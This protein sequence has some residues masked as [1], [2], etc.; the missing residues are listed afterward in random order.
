M[1]KIHFTIFVLFLGLAFRG[2]ALVE[3]SDDREDF[4]PRSSGAVQVRKSPLPNKFRPS[5]S[6]SVVKKAS[7]RYSPHRTVDLSLGVEAIDVG[8]LEK[9]NFFVLD[10]S[11][12]TPYNLFLKGYYRYASS[13]GKG[14]E[15]GRGGNPQLLVGVNWL[16]FGKATDLVTVD[17]Y[18]GLSLGQSDSAFASSRTDKFFG[19]QTNK[20]FYRMIF[21]IG[22]EQYLS[23]ASHMREK[24]IGNI[25]KFATSLSW[26]VS[27][28]ILFSL[29]AGTTGISPS[30][31][32]HR[33][34][35]LDEK[36]SWGYLSPL[37]KLNFSP[38]MALSL[39]ANFRVKKVPPEELWGAKLWNFKG[40]YGNSL[41]AALALNI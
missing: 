36:V 6:S 29:E 3:Y 25:R 35:G 22:F 12:R 17:F 1:K 4:R 28:D 19:F 8:A 24:E 16:R 27:A 23:G 31:S 2:Y 32:Y 9:S 20:R 10:T 14:E 11:L 38:A 33:R 37:M 30:E 34:W 21:G 7:P 39:K 15:E 13:Q 18:G 5:R 41:G 40:V 26:I